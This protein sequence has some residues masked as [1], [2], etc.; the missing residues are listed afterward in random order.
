MADDVGRMDRRITIDR[1]V[2]VPDSSG[3]VGSYSWN[4]YKGEWAAVKDISWMR[5][6][7]AGGE[8]STSMQSF[9]IPYDAQINTKDFSIVDNGYRYIPFAISET[10]GEEFQL[11]LTLQCKGSMV[12]VT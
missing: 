4:E 9:K 2:S 12:K 5:G 10:R 11:F 1:R 6:T 8:A 7:V 3:G